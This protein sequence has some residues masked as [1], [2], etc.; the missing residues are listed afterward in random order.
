MSGIER[1]E[2]PCTEISRI[3]FLEDKLYPI[4]KKFLNVNTN[5][6][7]FVTKLDNGFRIEFPADY[8]IRQADDVKKQ[9]S[10]EKQKS[11]REKKKWV[12]V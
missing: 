3:I 10:D 11:E 1:I 7:Y 4:G 9:I 8:I 5:G 12:K 2:V 6:S